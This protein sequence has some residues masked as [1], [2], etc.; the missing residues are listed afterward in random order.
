MQEEIKSDP[1]LLFTLPLDPSTAAQELAAISISSITAHPLSQRFP[2]TP[3]PVN[4]SQFTVSADLLPAG[5]AVRRPIIH[6]GSEVLVASTPLGIRDFQPQAPINRV[7]RPMSRSETLKSRL[8]PLRQ[9]EKIDKPR[10]TPQPTGG[11]IL[12]SLRQTLMASQPRSQ[13][14][15]SQLSFLVPQAPLSLLERIPRVVTKFV[16]ENYYY[17]RIILFVVIAIILLPLLPLP[18]L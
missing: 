18:F 13:V 11:G 17:I 14:D 3:L 9:P 16:L 7:I 4:R 1:P 12:E 10:S 2:S 15:G 8:H 5:I 6:N